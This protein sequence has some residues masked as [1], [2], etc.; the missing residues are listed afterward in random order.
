MHNSSLIKI[1]V[2]VTSEA[3]RNKELPAHAV[4]LAIKLFR[5]SFSLKYFADDAKAFALTDRLTN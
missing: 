2:V 4:R 1:I 5:V 3:K